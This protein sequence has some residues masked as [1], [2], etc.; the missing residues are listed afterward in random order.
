V[1]QATE[2]IAQQMAAGSNIARIWGGLIYNVKAYGAKGD[3]VTD[4]SSA[5]NAALAAAPAGS[6]I[7]IPTPDVT[8]RLSQT[9]TVNKPVRIVGSHFN[10]STSDNQTITFDESVL[11][12][13]NVTSKDCAIGNFS[14]KM[15]STSV[16]VVAGIYLNSDQGAGMDNSQLEDLFIYMNHIYGAG[17]KGKN[18]ITSQFKNVRPFQ[19]Q[20]GFYF[21]TAGTSLKFDNCWAMS[22]TVTGYYISAYEYI[23]FID[24]ACDTPINSDYAY[25]IDNTRGVAFTGCG[26]ESIAKSMFRFNNVNGVSVLGCRSV[27]TNRLGTGTA[28]FAELTGDATNVCFVGCYDDQGG[29]VPN[30]SVVGNFFPVAINCSF[31]N[32]KI[33]GVEY[34]DSISF[35]GG[36]KLGSLS[37]ISSPYLSEVSIFY[38]ND[39]GLSA[40]R[41]GVLSATGSWLGYID[42]DGGIVPRDIGALPAAS[43]AYEG[44]IF[45]VS[46]AAGV[47]DVLYVCLKSTANTFSWKVLATG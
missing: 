44:K 8:Y 12:G 39:L 37:L 24:C 40:R 14:I 27:A 47:A 30:V 46:G 41:F 25:H 17:V 11:T 36:I 23:D 13:F 21:D 10:V 28:T 42:N 29:V 16:S 38:G 9:F 18:V 6:T 26:A 15:N 22:S 45:R 2:L 5:F 3:G 7:F 35:R 34:K 1:S 19:G 31:P 4:D 32:I 33:N 20:Y 43:A